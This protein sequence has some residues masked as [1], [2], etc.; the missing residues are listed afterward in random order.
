MK[1]NCFGVNDMSRLSHLIL[2]LSL[3]ISLN[4]TAHAE[5]GSSLR[6]ILLSRNETGNFVE[7]MQK[8]LQGFVNRAGKLQRL[9]EGALKEGSYLDRISNSS[10]I[11]NQ[12]QMRPAYRFWSLFNKFMSDLEKIG[13]KYEVPLVFNHNK[14]VERYY[15]AYVLGVSARLARLIAA[16]DLMNFLAARPKL[17]E[18]LNEKNAEFGFDTNSLASTVK[19]ALKAENLAQ[20]YR[21]RISHYEELRKLVNN[22]QA[23]DFSNMP[24]VFILAN[25]EFLDN[26]SDKIASD[27]AWKFLSRSI[28]KVSLDFVL[29]AQK[30]IFSWVGDTRIKQKKTRLI[31]GEQIKRLGRML[32][33]GDIVLERQDWYLSNIFLPGFWPHS[34]LYVGTPDE[35]KRAFDS[36]REVR[37]WVQS[38]KCADFAELLKN[39]FPKANRAWLSPSF[40]DRET[41]VVIEAISEG[42]VFNSLA[43]SCH[44][45]Y[46]AAMRPRLTPLQ[47]AKAIY[48][49]FSYFNRE[50]D[51]NFSF[52]TE[53]TMVCTELVTKAYAAPEAGGL[54]FPVVFNFGKPGVTADSM[55][56]TFANER[57]KPNRQLDFVAFVR[58]FPGHRKAEFASEREFAGSHHW[59]GG[60][61]SANLK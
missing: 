44:G 7:D 57:G 27:P 13:E 37:R 38:Q 8:D 56:E 51:F 16:S 20:L 4:G 30:A 61:I 60:L 36:D 26:L 24:A 9:C 55:V 50:Y 6:Q 2:V 12:K 11:T 18:V 1:K 15:A 19:S 28:I 52:N 33:P 40:K 35:L 29:P 14:K 59:Q 43:S 39:A 5:N 22:D 49:A 10:D 21:F 31:T 25:Q 48:T 34:I 46:L 23:P 45:D 3:I 42:V 47:K 58:G 17:N 41:C 53:Q 32:E 54:K